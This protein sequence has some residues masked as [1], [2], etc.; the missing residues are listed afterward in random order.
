MPAT[1]GPRLRASILFF[2][3]SLAWLAH[4][5]GQDASSPPASVAPTPDSRARFTG[6][7]R[8]VGGP[9]ERAALDAA[10]DRVAHEFIFL[11]RPFVRS[12]MRDTNSIAPAITFTWSPGTMRVILTGPLRDYR[13][14]DDGTPARSDFSSSARIIHRFDHETLVERLTS[15]QGEQRNVYVLSADGRTLTMT[16]TITSPRIHVPVQYTLT[17]R[18]Q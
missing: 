7:Y 16:T 10:I 11:L 4:A 9:D 15:D 18:R 14:P 8:Y 3:V 13:A 2:M 1:D 17:Y 5:S 6:V 12:R